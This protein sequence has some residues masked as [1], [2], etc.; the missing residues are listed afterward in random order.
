MLPKFSKDPRDAA[1][2]RRCGYQWKAEEALRDLRKEDEN[3]PGE[4]EESSGSEKR[5]GGGG[6]GEEESESRTQETTERRENTRGMPWIKCLGGGGG[7][8]RRGKPLSVSQ[9]IHLLVKV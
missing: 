7:K 1:N 5:E 9:P 8:A 6:G 4:R 3:E 2:E